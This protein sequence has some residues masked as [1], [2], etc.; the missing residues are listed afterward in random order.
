MY[1]IAA[2]DLDGTL[3]SSDHKILPFTKKV[4]IQLHEQGKEFIFATGRHHID[5]A[6]MREQLGIPAFMITANGACVHNCQNDI[7]FQQ[8]VA[9]D[10][11]AA[12]IDMV[13]KDDEIIINLY[14]N[15]DWLV[16]KEDTKT[17]FNHDNFTYSFFDIDNPPL[18]NIAKI[19]LTREDQDH[20]KLVIWE[21]KIKAEFAQRA[22]IAFS[23]PSCL[24]VMDAG[25]SKGHALDAVAKMK[26]YQLKDCIAFGDG[27]NDYEMLSMAGKGVVMG[28]AHHK[29]KSA[30]PDNEVIGSSDDQAVAQY[31]V[32]HLLD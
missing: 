32:K 16:N 7:I 14:R 19:F 8:H 24:E 25:V 26:G 13:K 15:D 22:N 3:L 30:L 28:T 6:Q 23:S 10:I 9:Q 20:D 11:I 1:K 5:V 2:S 29:V 4:L 21:D 12:I 31:L 18:E 27:M 17:D